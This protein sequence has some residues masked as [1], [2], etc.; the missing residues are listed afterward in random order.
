MMLNS[1]LFADEWFENIILGIRTNSLLNAFNWITFLGETSVVIAITAAVVIFLFIF[2]K[3]KAYAVGFLTTIIGASGTSYIL[4]TLVERARPDGL[5][6]AV[7]ETSYSFPSGHATLAIALYG[8]L[9]YFLCKRYPKNSVL[10][11]TLATLII[12]AIGFSRLYLGVHFPSDVIAGYL[13][14]GIWLFI[15]IKITKLIR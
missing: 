5:I 6:P 9:T 11:I 15:G 7:T 8:F 4:K 1:I 12:L 13:L 10:I 14:G 3:N 2:K